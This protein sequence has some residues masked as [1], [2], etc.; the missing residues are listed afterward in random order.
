MSAEWVSD[1]FARVRPAL[2]KDMD[3]LAGQRI[4]KF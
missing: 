1:N 3:T 2:I 4:V